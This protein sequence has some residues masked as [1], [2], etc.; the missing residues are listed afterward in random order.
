VRF[1]LILNLETVS[2]Q[3]GHTSATPEPRAKVS[4]LPLL[5]AATLFLS[6]ALLFCIQPMAA[7]LV[8][9]SLGGS[10]AVWNTCLVFF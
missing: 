6:A 2:V 3:D 7:K 4:T 1:A 9:P 5:F 8:L 10:P